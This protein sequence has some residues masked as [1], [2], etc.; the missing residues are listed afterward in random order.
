MP[1][2]ERSASRTRTDGL[3]WTIIAVW[4][5]L[6][7]VAAVTLG[8]RGDAGPLPSGKGVLEVDV[9]IQDMRYVP[10]TVTV[11]RGSQLVIHLKNSDTKQ[12]DLKL[13]SGYSGR[14]DPGK[15]ASADFGTF[16]APAQGWCTIA[17]HKAMGMVF[18]VQ[19]AP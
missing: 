16:D 8:G 6:T 18:N 12:H 19:I 15:R 17:G 1:R 9:D 2:N 7:A 3:A 13:G 10:D 5:A 4:L 14:I 11:P